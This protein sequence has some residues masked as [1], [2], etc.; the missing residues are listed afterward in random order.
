MGTDYAAWYRLDD[1][2]ALVVE[3]RPEETLLTQL[4]SAVP[5]GPS[6]HE[7]MISLQDPTQAEGAFLDLLRRA[8][9]SNCALLA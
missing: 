2:S 1:H 7:L 6:W 5:Q 8:I 3:L 4:S 9:K